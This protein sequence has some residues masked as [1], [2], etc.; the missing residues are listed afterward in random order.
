MPYYRLLALDIDGTLVGPDQ[1][2]P[3]ETVAAVAEA[4]EAGLAV[5]LATGRSYAESIDVWRQLRLPAPA[6]PIVLV[7]GAIVSEPDTG[8]TLCQRTIAF[9]VACEFADALAEVGCVAMVLVDGWRWDVDYLVVET[10]DLHAAQRDWFSK[11]SVRVRRMAC[12]ADAPGAPEALRISTVAGPDAAGRI[13]DELRP[14]FDGRLN[15]HAIFAP[16]YDVTVVEAHAARA[17]KLAALEYIAQGMRIGRR[18]IAAVGDDINDLSMVRGAGLG[19][20]MPHAPQELLDAADHVARDGLA[21]FIRQLAGGGLDP[22]GGSFA[23][24]PAFG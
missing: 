10:G 20:A 24:E 13:A 9:D 12:L 4:H 23:D 5:C 18:R 14:R 16:N 8:R 2:V 11:M 21:G 1:V 15:V 19:A 17:T 3:A 7:G 22:A 6:G